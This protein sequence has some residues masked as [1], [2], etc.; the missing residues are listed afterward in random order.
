MTSEINDHL[1]ANGYL[2]KKR[3][4]VSNFLGGLAWGVGSVIGAT[5]VV[6]I[7]FGILN[8]LKWIPGLSEIADEVTRTIPKTPNSAIK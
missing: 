1:T 3:I 7:L 6:A 4:M 5:I 2:S 8:Q